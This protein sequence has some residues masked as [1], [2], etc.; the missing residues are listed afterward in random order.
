MIRIP[1]DFGDFLRLLNEHD[2]EYLLIGGYAVGYKMIS[3]A[4][5]KANK[6]AAGR[7]KDLDDLEHLP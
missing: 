7:H 4:D 3:L 5:L 6:R 1:P 2:V